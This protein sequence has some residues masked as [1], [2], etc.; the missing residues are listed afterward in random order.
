MIIERN[1][2]TYELNTDEMIYI[3]KKY[4]ADQDFQKLESL[5]MDIKER[6]DYIRA[7]SKILKYPLN[8]LVLVVNENDAIAII[9]SK[10]NDQAIMREN[11]LWCIEALD[12]DLREVIECLY[13]DKISSSES[14]YQKLYRLRTKAIRELIFQVHNKKVLEPI[15]KKRSGRAEIIKANMNKVRFSVQC[16]CAIRR[17]GV[18]IPLTPKEIEAVANEVKSDLLFYT[19]YDEER[20]KEINIKYQEKIRRGM[21]IQTDA[22]NYP[23]PVNLLLQKLLG[24]YEDIVDFIEKSNEEK[25]DI[26]NGVLWAISILPKDQKLAIEYHYRDKMKPKNGGALLGC[27]GR[28]FSELRKQ[29]ERKMY[30]LNHPVFHSLY[31]NGYIATR[32][33]Y[34]E[35]ME[36]LQSLYSET[37]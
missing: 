5:R 16:D 11:F 13:R 32:E 10:A 33:N 28:Y 2:V 1:G 18:S 15:K 26:M 29:G 36:R 20:Q 31:T 14:E 7:K 19:H 24:W 21:D 23:Y 37:E 4:N 34:N 27:D 8:V 17:N 35:E 9:R 30:H 22:V 12:P 3:S 6:K 25:E